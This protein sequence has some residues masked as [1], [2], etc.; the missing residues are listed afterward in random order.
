MHY[1]GFAIVPSPTRA[2]VDAAMDPHRDR[3]DA[4]GQFDWYRPGGRWDGYLVSDGEMKARET[5]AGFDFAP[6]NKSIARNCCRANAVPPGRRSVAFFV[7][8]GRWIAQQRW[9]PNAP[10]DWLPGERGAYVETPGFADLLDAALAAHP[11]HWVVV[12][13]AHD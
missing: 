5:A 12:V 13:D 8:D 7:V 2:A 3:N 1:L 10:S 11:D 9:D 6:R 4:M